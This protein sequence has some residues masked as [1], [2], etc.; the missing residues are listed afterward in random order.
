MNPA[1]HDRED[2]GIASELEEL[3]AEERKVPRD[4]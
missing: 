4:A 1:R 3:P 2:V